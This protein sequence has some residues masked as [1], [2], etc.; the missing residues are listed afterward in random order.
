MA[1]KIYRLSSSGTWQE[2]KKLYRMSSSGIWGQIKKIYRLSSSG[3]WSLIFTSQEA[4]IQSLK[5]TLTGNAQAG[6]SLTSTSGEYD[7][8]FSLTTRIAYSTSTASFVDST[9]GSVSSSFPTSIQTSPYTVTNSDAAV[10]TVPSYKPSYYYAAV[11]RVEY[12]GDGKYYFYY[13]TPVLSFIQPTVTTPT[14]SN[15]T[16]SGFTVSWTSGPSSYHTS[17]VLIYNSSQQLIATYTSQTTPFVWSGGSEGTTYYAKIKVTASD[18]SGTNVTSDFSSSITTSVTPT[19]SD[20]T[21]LIVYTHDPRVT[22]NN[23]VA[24][25]SAVSGATYYRYWIWDV[26]NQTYLYSNV[27][28]T[29][30]ETTSLNIGEK[31]RIQIFV[32][33]EAPGYN[34]SLYS[35]I[36]YNCGPIPSV[37][38]SFNIYNH[39]INGTFINFSHSGGA[40]NGVYLRSDMFVSAHTNPTFNSEQYEEYTTGIF[41]WDPASTLYIYFVSN[42]GSVYNMRLHAYTTGK[43]YGVDNK[44]LTTSYTNFYYIR[45]LTSASGTVAPITITNS[46][47]IKPGVQ[48]MI[49]QFTVTSNI[50]NVHFF[51]VAVQKYTSNGQ[52]YV[53]TQDTE[54]FTVHGRTEGTNYA[55]GVFVGWPPGGLSALSYINKSFTGLESGHLYQVIAW[56]FSVAYDSGTGFYFKYGTG[57]FVGQV[58]V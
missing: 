54:Y 13:G 36:F 8:Y 58:I 32:R 43:L 9:T 41:T 51:E 39:A 2:I 31:R 56:P 27:T 3:I 35:Y 14:L 20:P 21:N 57:I 44:Y 47:V 10:L 11:D 24:K 7:S 4:P 53:S 55:P 38:S 50:I 28:T 48:S 1:P 29:S 23:F 18:S 52:T 34:S 25:W 15:A 5:P 30:T 6:T 33:A 17:D 22:T 19:L 12:S 49:Y 45:S 16:T 46:S 26:T 37:P 40:G 42:P